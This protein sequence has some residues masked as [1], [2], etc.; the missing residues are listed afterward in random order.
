[1]PSPKPHMLPWKHQHCLCR[2]ILSGPCRDG[3]RRLQRGW[4]VHL[5]LSSAASGIAG[6]QCAGRLELQ[7]CLSVQQRPL[8]LSC[9]DCIFT[10]RRRACRGCGAGWTRCPC[11]GCPPRW[12]CWGAPSPPTSPRT[13]SAPQ[14]SCRRAPWH[15]AAARELL[16]E[17]LATSFAKH[18]GQHLHRTV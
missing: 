13:R 4:S 10:G 17:H 1:M 3:L 14:R 12:P 16:L 5:R 18:A 9:H 11:S 15:A 7:L 2:C 8:F 6:K